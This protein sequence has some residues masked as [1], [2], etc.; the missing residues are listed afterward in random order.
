MVLKN[1]SHA[2]ENNWLV[3]T[4]EHLE[5]NYEEYAEHCE[6]RFYDELRCES[7]EQRSTAKSAKDLCLMKYF[8]SKEEEMGS[9]DGIFGVFISRAVC[10]AR[11]MPD[12]H[13]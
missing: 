10:G 1:L 8:T 11:G 12:F 7:W 6:A 3:I 2:R 5:R 9:K 4:H 13:Y